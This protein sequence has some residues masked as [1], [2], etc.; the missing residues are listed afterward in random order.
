MERLSF[1]GKWRKLMK[2]CKKPKLEVDKFEKKIYYIAICSL[3][4]RPEGNK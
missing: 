4:K 3:R 1:W 2:I